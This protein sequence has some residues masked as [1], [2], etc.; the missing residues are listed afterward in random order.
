MKRGYSC[1]LRELAAR[2]DIA[3]DEEVTNDYAT[4]TSDPHFS[5]GCSCG[6]PLC[7][8]TM[9]GNDWRLPE[10]RQR[11]GDHW[12]PALITRIGRRT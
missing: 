1:G 9:T 6:S 10:L 3:A 2:R 7:R 4:S 8:D 12:V 11:Y 5:M